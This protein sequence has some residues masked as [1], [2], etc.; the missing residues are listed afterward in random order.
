VSNQLVDQLMTRRP[1]LLLLAIVLTAVGAVRPQANLDKDQ[2]IQQT[3]EGERDCAK[4]DWD[5]ATSAQSTGVLKTDSLPTRTCRAVSLSWWP[6]ARIVQLTGVVHRDVFVSI[7][8]VQVNEQS[9]VQLVRAFGGLVENR[10]REDDPGNKAVF[11]ELLRISAYRPTDDRMLEL[12]ALYL[13]M[14]GHPP[15]E[16]PRKLSDVMMISDI[17]GIVTKD[18]RW[19]VVTVHQR[20]SR[21]GPFGNPSKN[22]VLKF[23]KEKSSLK[24]VSVAPE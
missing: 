5:F 14:V 18:H 11:N 22:W 20:T 13:F 21:F 12:A 2:M 23:R 16:L 3:I 19:T 4:G 15:D 24:L 9:P 7:T 17:L 6:S 8:L 1:V 10:D